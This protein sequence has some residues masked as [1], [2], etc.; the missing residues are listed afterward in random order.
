MLTRYG[1]TQMSGA[2]RWSSFLL[3]WAATGALA[4]LDAMAVRHGV[5]LLATALGARSPIV[6]VVD[7]VL[8][9]VLMLCWIGGVLY[10]Q[11]VYAE[12][13]NGETGPQRIVARFWRITMVELLILAAAAAIPAG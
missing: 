5:I 9:V 12:A 3:A 7:Q 11:H 10:A 4:L 2:A 8:L 13:V 1:A 6:R